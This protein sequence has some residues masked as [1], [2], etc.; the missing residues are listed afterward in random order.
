MLT[1]LA[2]ATI[3][4][5]GRPSAS[6]FI[7][8]AAPLRWLA[9]QR[10]PPPD[11]IRADFSSPTLQIG[12]IPGVGFPLERSSANPFLYFLTDVL[13]NLLDGNFPPTYVL[14]QLL[15]TFGSGMLLAA[16]WLRTGSIWPLMLLHAV[17][18]FGRIVSLNVD[19]KSLSSIDSLSSIVGGALLCAL[20]LA[21]ALFLLRPSQ[22]RWL[23]AY[24]EKNIPLP[25]QGRGAKNEP[26]SADRHF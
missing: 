6:F 9:S 15:V 23:R 5:S 19:P 14:G 12:A 20:L 26:H 10:F 13:V 24:Y 2:V 8:L 11:R 1:A 3:I 7:G 4:G 25:E 22:L 18:D 17:R 21:Y 16:L